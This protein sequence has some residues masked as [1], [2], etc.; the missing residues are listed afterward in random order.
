MV[1]R[2]VARVKK[3]LSQLS[4]NGVWDDYIPEKSNEAKIRTLFDLSRGNFLDLDDK[5]WNDLNLFSLMK[6]MDSCRTGVGRQYLY[7]ILRNQSHSNFSDGDKSRDVSASFENNKKSLHHCFSPLAKVSTSDSTKLLFGS[8]PVNPTNLLLSLIWFLVSVCAM[9]L[10]ILLGSWFYIVAGLCVALNVLYSFYSENKD[11]L[12]Q[13][14]LQCVNG[15]RQCAK[16]IR[17]STGSNETPKNPESRGLGLALSL[18]QF[19]Q[20]SPHLIV[21]NAAYIVNAFTAYDGLISAICLPVI[22][23]NLSSIREDF[24]LIG[25]LDSHIAIQAYLKSKPHVSAVF[26][27]EK[28]LTL[29]GVYH[30]SIDGCVPNDVSSMGHSL[31]ITGSNMSGKTSFVRA[32]GI[33]IAVANSIGICFAKQALIPRSVV[34]SSIDISDSIAQGKS[35]FYT[36]LE[37]IKYIIETVDSAHSLN[38]CIVDEIFK[39]TN[40]TERIASAAAVL[41]YLSKKYL[42]LVTSHDAELYDFTSTDYQPYYFSETDDLSAPFDYKLRQGR[43][44]KRNAIRLMTDIGIPDEIV[45]EARSL[46]LKSNDNV[47]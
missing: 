17:Q 25:S 23:R 28:K 26:T 4:S 6:S 13:F 9:F 19:S 1:D 8:A 7:R 45:L 11:S 43:S 12:S 41:N 29:T 31:L 46:V 15:I 20:S 30:P 37:R 42:V 32:V 35:Y 47:V 14:D 21:N 33:N 10:S 34:I 3:L 5:T 22:H 27:D 44:S 2:I 38:I 24:E 18:M 16:R 36:E 40:T 39:G